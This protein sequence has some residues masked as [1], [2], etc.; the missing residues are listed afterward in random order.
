M[1]VDL[2]ADLRSTFTERWLKLQIQVGPPPRPGAPM[3]STAPA[4]RD[5]APPSAADGGVQAG[6]R[7][8]HQHDV[9]PRPPVPGG[10]PPPGAPVPSPY[11]GVGRNDPC[12]C[13]SGKKFKRCHGA[14]L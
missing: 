4:G 10:A 11:A 13:G 6:C 2:M 12:P 1:F 7:R 5:D 14:T 3:T 9:R 8:A